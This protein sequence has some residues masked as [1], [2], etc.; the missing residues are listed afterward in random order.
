[1]SVGVV[2]GEDPVSLGVAPVL[3]EPSGRFWNGDKGNA[4]A[5]Q[6]RACSSA[7]TCTGQREE[8]K[9]FT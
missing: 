1:M 4:D 8:G 3:D 9:I 2:G 5:E 7:P 6:T